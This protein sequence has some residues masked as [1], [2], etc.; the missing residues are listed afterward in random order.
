MVENSYANWY[1]NE[2]TMKWNNLWDGEEQ[3]LLPGVTSQQGFYD[4]YAR[5][6]VNDDM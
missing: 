2:L 5:K 1:L 6:F 3:W 4:R